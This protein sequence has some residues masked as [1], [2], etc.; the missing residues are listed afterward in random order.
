MSRPLSFIQ[1]LSLLAL[2]ALL[3]LMTIAQRS[4]EP[5]SGPKPSG[6]YAVGRG[7]FYCVDP[8]RTDPVAEDSSTKREFMVVVWYPEEGRA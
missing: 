8:H 5:G 7:L 1:S 3:P 6:N 4:G 2:V